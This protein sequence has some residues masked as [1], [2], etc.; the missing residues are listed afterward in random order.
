M[1][2]ELCGEASSSSQDV[3]VG[4]EL[5]ELFFCIAVR[6]V[7][8]E[9]GGDEV[10][11]RGEGD[12]VANMWSA[13]SAEGVVWAEEDVAADREV[14]PVEDGDAYERICALSKE[15]CSRRIGTRDGETAAGEML[16]CPGILDGGLILLRPL[17]LQYPR[18][19]RRTC[20]TAAWR[21]PYRI[22]AKGKKREKKER[23]ECVDLAGGFWSA[24]EDYTTMQHRQPA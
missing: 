6:E 7:E 9:E 18:L 3:L 4:F 2:Y 5:L 11:L 22:S 8:D 1:L 19:L 12:V 20:C 17:L 15:H 10:G 16:R 14:V 24:D 21:C 13:W 23:H